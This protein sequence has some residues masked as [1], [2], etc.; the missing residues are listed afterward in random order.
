MRDASGAVIEKPAGH[1]NLR[2]TRALEPGFVLTIEPGIYFID[3]LLEGTHSSGFAG[4]INW[5]RVDACRKFG[6][7]RIEDNVA[8]T[9]DGRDNLTRS[10]FAALKH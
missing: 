8:V 6:G 10:A 3:S 5:P 4:Q 2:L 1:P 7:I 9:A